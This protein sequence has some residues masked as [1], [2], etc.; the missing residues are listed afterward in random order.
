MGEERQGKSL[1]L[2]PTSIS[3]SGRSCLSSDGI[4]SV[5]EGKA[6]VALMQSRILAAT[7]PLL[8][9]ERRLLLLPT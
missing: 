9:E 7:A 1:S 8:V 2:S 3:L 6:E 5:C 4:W